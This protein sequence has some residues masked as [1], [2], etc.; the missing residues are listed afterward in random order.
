MYFIS[1]KLYEE[2]TSYPVYLQITINRKT[3]KLRSITKIKLTKQEYQEYQ[4]RGTYYNEKNRRN[5]NTSDYLAKEL[6][7]VTLSLDYF[8]NKY[9]GKQEQTS[10]KTVV[11]FY[12]NDFD[13]AFFIKDINY[14]TIFAIDHVD[15]NFIDRIIKDDVMPLDII[16]FFQTTLKTDLFTVLDECSSYGLGGLFYKSVSLFFSLMPKDR[17]GKIIGKLIEWYDGDLQNQFKKKLKAHK[18]D[19]DMYY[20]P[21][22]DFCKNLEESRFN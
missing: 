1:G 22:A 13:G 21:F 3:T 10:I 8:Y 12:M 2:C 15:Y 11:N 9:N 6:E 7:L 14:E 16:D 20:Q 18:Y 19:V 5:Y 4:K 17:K